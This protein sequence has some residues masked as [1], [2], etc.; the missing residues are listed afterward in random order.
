MIDFKSFP[1]KPFLRA[2]LVKDTHSTTRNYL[3]AKPFLDFLESIHAG[4]MHWLPNLPSK[5][6]LYKQLDLLG[7]GHSI[8]SDDPHL[9]KQLKEMNVSGPPSSLCTLLTRALCPSLHKLGI[10][11]VSPLAPSCPLM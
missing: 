4:G 3:V 6:T 11:L 1:G 2:T 8:T 5:T 7:H 9:L 10:S